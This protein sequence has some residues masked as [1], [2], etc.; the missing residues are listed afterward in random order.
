MLLYNGKRVFVY[1]FS[2]DL[3]VEKLCRDITALEVVN[4][5]TSLLVRGKLVPQR[6]EY[7]PQAEQTGSH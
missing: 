1:V 4:T 2:Q 6:L 7:R 3:H 5:I